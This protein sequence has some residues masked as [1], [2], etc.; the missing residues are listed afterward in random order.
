M[1]VKTWLTLNNFNLISSEL[2]RQLDNVITV[3]HF[4]MKK[5]VVFQEKK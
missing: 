3:G 2:L 5:S 1:P 4:Q